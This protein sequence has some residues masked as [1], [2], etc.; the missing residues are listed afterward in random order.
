[1]NN[2]GADA[3]WSFQTGA[4]DHDASNGAGGYSPAPGTSNGAQRTPLHRTVSEEMQQTLG[5]TLGMTSVNGHGS[6]S[7]SRGGAGAGGGAGP[8]PSAASSS[9]GAGQS[10]R[11][12]YSGFDPMEHARLSPSAFDPSSFSRQFIVPRFASGGPSDPFGLGVGITDP[13][14]GCVPLSLCRARRRRA[15]S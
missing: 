8:G 11:A 6:S 4:D 7:S 2:N 10:G 9:A 1:M 15:A 5:A 3:Y 14:S 12:S 13:P